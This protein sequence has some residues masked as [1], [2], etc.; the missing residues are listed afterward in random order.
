MSNVLLGVNIDHVATLRNVRGTQ[1][2][3]PFDVI[4]L[5]TKG[6]ADGITIHLREDRRHIID[7][8]VA[9]I[10][11]DKRLPVNLEIAATEEMLDIAI[12]HQPHEVCLVP[13][14]R[15]ELTTEGGLNVL[16]QQ[17]YL[18][19]YIAQL[20][21]NGILV[22][23]FI[24]ADEEQIQ[25]S[26]DCGADIIELHTGKYAEFEMH[27][28]AW[29]EEFS[30]L[31]LAADQAHQLGLTVNAGHGLTAQNTAEIAN[32]QHMNCLNIGHS[33]IAR[34]VF[35]GLVEAVTEIKALL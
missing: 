15:Q 27:S 5:L 7:N 12:A 22:S 4:E 30:R 32:I 14:K 28:Q 29:Q 18:T 11:A 20:K 21:Q 33:I 26:A 1:Y 23:L 19:K 2:P 8:D 17:D 10:C 9:R 13:E 3:D 16:T 34:S 25:A 24:D 6:G 31:S 35:V